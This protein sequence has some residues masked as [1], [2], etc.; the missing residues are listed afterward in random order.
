M[1][2]LIIAL[3]FGLGLLFIYGMKKG[4]NIKEL[5][6]L[7]ATGVRTTKKILF[8][9]SLIGILTALW[10]SCGTLPVIICYASKLILPSYFILA[11]FLLNCLVSI[12]TGTAFG[13]AATMGTI[14]MVTGAALQINPL[15]TGGA[16]MSGVYFGDRCSP[17]STSALLVSTLTKTDLY[18]NIKTMWKTALVPFLTTCVIYFLAGRKL[19][20][21]GEML[22]VFS[23][24]QTDFELEAICLLPAIL[25]LLLS[26]C[27]M[28]VIKTMPL[29]ILCAFILGVFIQDRTL[30]ELLYTM[31]LGFKTS[32]P[33]L[34]LLINGGGLISMCRVMAIVCI[35]SC[36]SEILQKT[37]LLSSI[38]DFIYKTSEKITPHGAIW[39][40]SFL[41][42][43]IAFNQTLTIILTHQI[44]DGI[45]KD[46]YKFAAILE[47]TAVILPGMIPWSIACTTPLT[48]IGASTACLLT[49][50][51]LYL[52]LIYDLFLILTEKKAL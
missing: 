42:S 43:L 45:E 23:M 21:E 33:E 17:M 14:C 40:A 29:S 3:L 24:F 44:C 9:F 52:L 1:N 8:I 38:K 6:R 2:L 12:L 7:A 37:G 10:R 25:I 20:S 11:A 19:T 41:T 49:S 47:N 4:L 46:N 35:S 27:K 26:F 18:Q 31:I 28:P 48:T 13:T 51:F 15:W 5:L 16:V 34:A 32:N 22:D 50:C 39:V 30:P 36:Y